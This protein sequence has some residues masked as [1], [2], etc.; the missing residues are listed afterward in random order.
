MLQ[1]Q[2]GMC[3]WCRIH[4]C[5]S[6]ESP[7]RYVDRVVHALKESAIARVKMVVDIITYLLSSIYY[8][9]NEIH[10]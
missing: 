7:F 2:L 10:K 5:F 4:I 3:G 9:F 8:R 1:T 6:A